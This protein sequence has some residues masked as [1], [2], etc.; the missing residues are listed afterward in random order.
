ML[1]NCVAEVQRFV[2]VDWKAEQR[3][4]VWKYCWYITALSEESR[5]T[6]IDKFGKWYK[7]SI[8]QKADIKESDLIVI[9]G[10]QYTTKG[11]AFRKWWSL[12]LTTA[13]L[14]LW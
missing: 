11:V 12:I 3:T 9:D 7:L 8:T 4:I 14:E 6:E 2:Y 1:H 5:V 13:I 10:V